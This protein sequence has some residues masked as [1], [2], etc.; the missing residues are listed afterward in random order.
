MSE[1]KRGP[2]RPPNKEKVVEV[3]QEKMNEL[4][5]T[6]ERTL[7]G[8]QEVKE[9]NENLQKQLN[10][11]RTNPSQ[12]EMQRKKRSR[13]LD[14]LSTVRAVGE[15]VHKEGWRPDPP[16]PVFLLGKE[17]VKVWTAGWENGHNLTFDQ[18]S[19]IAQGRGELPGPA[20]EEIAGMSENE[21][22]AAGAS[23]SLPQVEAV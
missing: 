10:R 11:S 16:E 20:G 17:A 19:E 5:A 14:T 12:A 22:N 6:M 21:L 18:V 2:G 13:T 1:T 3:T 9:Q 7:A 23:H 8:Y 4:M 15:V